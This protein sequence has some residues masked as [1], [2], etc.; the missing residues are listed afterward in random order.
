MA[1][2]RRSLDERGVKSREAAILGQ[3]ARGAAPAGDREDDVIKIGR[4]LGGCL[5]RHALGQHTTGGAA[6]VQPLKV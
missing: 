5:E 3:T 2:N 6:Q 4:A 1:M